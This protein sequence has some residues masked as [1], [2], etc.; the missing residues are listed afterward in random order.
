VSADGSLERFAHRQVHVGPDYE[1][2]RGH[3]RGDGK[4]SEADSVCLHGCWDRN[5]TWKVARQLQFATII[6]CACALPFLDTSKNQC[7]RWCA[8]E[9]C[10]TLDKMQRYRQG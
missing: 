3:G 10:D 4:T 6:P 1:I 8:M 9:T 2:S 7:R 5:P